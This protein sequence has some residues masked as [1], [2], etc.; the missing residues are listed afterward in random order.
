LKD[1]TLGKRLGAHARVIGFLTM[2][3]AATI[4]MRP[5]AAQFNAPIMGWSTYSQQTIYGENWIT[6]GEIEVQSAMIHQSL[7]QY[8]FN[9]V[10]V[11]AGS[12]TGTYDSYGRPMQNTSLYPDGLAAVAAYVHN[13]GQKFGLYYVPGI[14]SAL[15][16]QNPPIYGTNPPIYIQSIVKTPYMPG[17]AWGSTTSDNNYEIDYTKPGAQAYINSIANLFATWGF[18]YLKLDGVCPGSDLGLPSYDQRNDVAAWQTALQ[19][20]GRP[21][22]L[23]ISWDINPTYSSFFKQYTNACRIDNDIE[24]YNTGGVPLTGWTQISGRF[25]DAVNWCNSSGIGGG[26]EDL[27]SLDCG[28]GSVDGTT[29]DERQTM[30]TFWSLECANWYTGDDPYHLDTFG[31]WLLTNPALIHYDQAGHVA[32]QIQ[33]GNSQI[34]VTPNGDGTYLVGLFN[35]SGSSATVTINWS[36]LNLTGSQDVFDVLGNADLGQFSNSYGVTLNTHA[37]K[38]IKVGGAGVTWY[39]ISNV[40]NNQSLTLN[41]GW[42]VDGGGLS[43]AADTGSPTQ[44]W[45]LVSQSNGS[46]NLVNEFSGKMVNIPGGAGSNGTQLIQYHK[47]GG[48]NSQWKKV[49]SGSNYTFVSVDSGLLMELAG[50]TIVDE[51]GSNGGTNQQWVVTPCVLNDNDTTLGVSYSGTSWSYSSNRNL[52]DYDNDVHWTNHSG[53]S[54]TATFTGTGV[55]YVTEK[56]NDEGNVN[57]YIDGVLQST[58]NC[59]NSTRLVQQP[60]YSIGGLTRGTHTIQVVNN[61]STDMLIDE[62][63]IAP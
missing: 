30:A 9:Y 19:Q 60:V 15:Y 49:A 37:S 4:G 2:A 57:I 7:Q 55:T 36:S 46:Y 62:F 1:Y 17:C 25:S 29:N 28:E 20:C 35:L 23:T 58:V 56:C 6:E 63:L 24:A 52:G 13:N 12:M 44:R 31:T 43:S 47:D 48:S 42:D 54:C 50:G 22:F 38:L 26:W 27:D 53:D 11:D 34:W 21:V 18:D 33:S 3:V 8:G 10:N 5:A 61:A 45:Q 41:N 32:N 51:W 40:S 39:K 59:Y 16:D 14:P